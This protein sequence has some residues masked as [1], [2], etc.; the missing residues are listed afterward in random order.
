MFKDCSIKTQ[1]K[2]LFALQHLNV[3]PYPHHV[4]VYG[5]QPLTIISQQYVTKVNLTPDLKMVILAYYLPVDLMPSGQKPC[6]F[7]QVIEN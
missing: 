7:V 4:C 5:T 6:R 1:R 3:L 2:K